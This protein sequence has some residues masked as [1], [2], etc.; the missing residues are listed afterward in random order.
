M[1]CSI[2]ATARHI[3]GPTRAAA[4]FARKMKSSSQFMARTFQYPLALGFVVRSVPFS[5]VF[6]IWQITF[7]LIC[8]QM[9]YVFRIA[10]T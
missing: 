9:H 5:D 4:C 1:H 7:N 2:Y 10:R 8:S 3:L 6:A